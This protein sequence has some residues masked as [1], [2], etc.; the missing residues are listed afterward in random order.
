MPS[1]NTTILLG[2][3]LGY[4]GCGVSLH[5]CSSKAQPLLLTLDQGY[6]LTAAPP[7][8]EH[9][10]APL[11]HPAPGSSRSLEVGLLLS[12][13]APDLGCGSGIKIQ[14]KLT[15][16]VFVSDLTLGSLFLCLVIVSW[17]AEFFYF[18]FSDDKLHSA[19]LTLSEALYFYHNASILYTVS[20]GSSCMS[21]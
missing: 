3:G 12:A 16:H 8:L 7:D 11:G 6:L 13:T 15:A 10:V 2:L 21:D 18:F 4:L 1:H 20:L 5:S 17:K 14:I 19:V 9:G